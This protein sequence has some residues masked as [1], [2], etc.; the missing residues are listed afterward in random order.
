MDRLVRRIVREMES[1][2][3][4]EQI[5]ARNRTDKDLVEQICRIYATHPG[6]DVDGI[7]NRMEIR[8]R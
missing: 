7:L 6:V 4:V 8:G 1:G 5:A 3:S 2:R